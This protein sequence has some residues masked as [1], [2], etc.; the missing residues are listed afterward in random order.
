M[1]AQVSADLTPLPALGQRVRAHELTPPTDTHPTVREAG[2]TPLPPPWCAGL[3]QH[4]CQGGREAGSGSPSDPP[5]ACFRGWVPP[6][7]L[8]RNAKPPQAGGPS[9]RH[10]PRNR[11]RLGPKPPGPPKPAVSESLPPAA[12]PRFRPFR[13]PS[14]TDSLSHF[15]QVAPSESA[16]DRAGGSSL[17]HCRLTDRLTEV[18][19]A[20]RGA[21]RARKPN[22]VLANGVRVTSVTKQR[23]RRSAPVTLVREALGGKSP[24]SGRVTRRRAAWPSR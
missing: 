10:R 23:S 16:S 1:S 8:P 22:S 5:G 2:R 7:S 3:R 6:P 20:V 12:D 18:G 24:R 17:I 11:F 19:E 13:R 14:V 4:P 15:S 9:R 21:W